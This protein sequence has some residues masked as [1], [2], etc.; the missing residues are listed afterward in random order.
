MNSF[1]RA[2]AGAGA[3]VLAGAALM[4]SPASAEA[5]HSARVV[6]VPCNSAALAT[7]INTANGL[8]AATLRLA[9]NCVYSITNP[10]DPGVDGL[11]AITADVALI[12]GVSTTIRRD[13]AAS[14]TFRVI[15]VASTGTLH[16]RNL[17]IVGGVAPND[18]GGILNNGIAVLS[19]VTLAGNRSTDF[20]GGFFNGTGATAQISDSVI[21]AN[22]A[23]LGGGGFDNAG[24]LTVFGSRLTA[25]NATNGGGGST[26]ASGTTRVIRS[27]IDR[28]FAAGGGGG[29]QGGGTTSIDRVLVVHNRA[30]TGGGI[31]VSGGTVTTTNSII[32]TNIPDNCS[33]AGSVLGCFG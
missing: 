6:R 31:F 21:K 16:A 2:F 25:N 26:D 17:F 29:L 19:F 5:A 9:S 14:T 12:G 15:D 30:S 11:P 18:G 7:A 24:R 27:T 20:G 33:P 13:P 22:A 4:T 1:G 10:A 23:G 32:R 28:N 3:T 8:G